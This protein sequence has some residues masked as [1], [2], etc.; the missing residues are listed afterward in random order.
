MRTSPCNVYPL[1]PHFYIVKVGFTGVFII[2]LFLLQNIDCGYSL[3]PPHEAVLTCTHNLCFEQKYENSQKHSTKNCHF[4]G[5]DILLYIAW[6]CL[7]NEYKPGGLLH[8]YQLDESK[9]MFGSSG[10]VFHFIFRWN[11]C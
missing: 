3:E 5:S 9:L 8:P 4:Y 11:F 10:V 1:T 2:F 6:A 7:R